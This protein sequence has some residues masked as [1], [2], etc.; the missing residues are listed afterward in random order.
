MTLV[1][2]ITCLM[3]RMVRYKKKINK[4]IYSTKARTDVVKE[5]DRLEDQEKIMVINPIKQYKLESQ[6]SNLP[7]EK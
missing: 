3:S 7:Q 4:K 6:I 2:P 5:I 1:E